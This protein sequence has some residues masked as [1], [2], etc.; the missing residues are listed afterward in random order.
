MEWTARDQA[1]VD[2]KMYGDSAEAEVL[3]ELR[4]LDIQ[5][6]PC[7]DVCPKCGAVLE[8]GSGMVGEM[9]LWC[10]N[11]NC[12]YAWCDEEGAIRRVY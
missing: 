5:N 2:A 7:P 9:M 10:T 11:K 4:R 8:Q 12:T 3:V 1:I 6:E